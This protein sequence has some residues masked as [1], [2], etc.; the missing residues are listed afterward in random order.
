MSKNLHLLTYLKLFFTATL[1]GGT[2]IAGRIISNSVE[3]FSAAFLRFTIASFILILVTWRLGGHPAEAKL[4]SNGAHILSW[5][6]GR[7]LL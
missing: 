5:H 4:G 3:P 7:F 1:W 2:F 6:D